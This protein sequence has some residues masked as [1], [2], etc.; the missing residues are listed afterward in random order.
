M[1]LYKVQE[2]FGERV[3]ITMKAYPLFP[4]DVPGRKLGT[5]S[6]MGRMRA[7]MDAQEDGILFTPWP[8]ERPMPSTSMAALEAAKCAQLQGAE[9]FKRY[10]LALFK[11][12]FTDCLDIADRDVLVRLAEEV[13]LE[14]G[15]F[16]TELE[17]ASQQPRVVMEFLECV[18]KYNS[19]AQG[20]P[21][22]TF[23]DGP[24]L[25]GCAPLAVYRTAV[26]R[27]LDPMAALG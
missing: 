27:Q 2:E 13:G 12:F 4:N 5:H 1:R 10:D 22:H 18:E 24:P 9:A 20:I 19:W 25:V 21:L 3:S 14:R 11:A 15:P 16:L 6:V 23:N 7:G 8:E 26:L 17:S